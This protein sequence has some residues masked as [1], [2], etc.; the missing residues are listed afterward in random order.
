MKKLLTFACLYAFLFAL[1]S[2]LTACC[3]KT[4]EAKEPEDE[5][6]IDLITSIVGEV[7]VEE[8][9]IE[10]AP[11]AYSGPTM[12][13]INLK[14]VNN[15]QPRGSYKLTTA[16]G[17]AIIESGELGVPVEVNQGLYSIEFKSADVFGE[18]SY[19]MADVEVKGKEYTVEAIFPAGQITLHTYER[20]KT[21][22]CKAT[23]FT[24]YSET[25]EQKLEGKG[26]SCEPVVL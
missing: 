22:P 23:T 26:K 17:T 5:E 8:E 7:E 15:K 21:G 9:A 3:G 25:L 19:L 16:E 24:V 14:V 18:P 1:M 4:P 6:D 13:T 12:L 2:Q 20:K 11:E 10:Q